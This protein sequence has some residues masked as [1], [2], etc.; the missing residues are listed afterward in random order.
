MKRKY[1]EVALAL[2]LVIALIAGARADARQVDLSQKL[3]RLHVIANS[4]TEADQALKLRVRDRVISVSETL[5]KGVSD[6]DTARG[7]I[8]QNLDVIEAAANDTVKSAGFSY[9]VRA[10]VTNMY[11]PT[12]DYTS[13]SLPAG[14]YNAFRIIIGAGA[15]HNWWCVMF[16]PLC[17]TA[18][19]AEVEKSARDAGLSDDEIN[20]IQ[21]GKTVYRYKFKVIE[22][23]EELK[24]M[25]L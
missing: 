21:S 1:F 8:S 23:I 18:A 24:N 16:P 3:M 7:I 22:W 19:E 6:V 10:E 14:N 17:I 13:F 2:G 25:F 20:L 4:D 9:P 15:G 11:F 5:L 12:R